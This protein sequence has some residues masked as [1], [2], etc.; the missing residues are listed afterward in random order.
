MEDSFIVNLNMTKKYKRILKGREVDLSDEGS[1]SLFGVFDGHSGDRCSKYISRIITRDIVCN[2]FYPEDIRTALI[3]GFSNADKKFLKLARKKKWEDGSTGLVALFA[4]DILYV[5][6]AG[7]SRAVLCRSGETIA[8]SEDHKPENDIERERIEL[9]GGEVTKISTTWRING[10]LAVSRG[11]G[12]LPY[13]NEETLEEKF[14][15]VEPDIT[16]NIIDEECEF[17]ILAC[18]GLWDVCTNEEAVQFVKE[19]LEKYDDRRP[20]NLKSRNE[21]LFIVA[22]ELTKYAYEK[23]STDNISCLIVEIVH[24]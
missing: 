22:I 12:D 7:D 2:E 13:K 11:F 19:N 23:G 1:Y 4:E 20:D 24:E 16:E 14:V 21:H 5:A 17:I 8:L 3:Q 9:Y 18:D 10:R 6:N 15:T